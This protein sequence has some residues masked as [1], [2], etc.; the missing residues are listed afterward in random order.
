M[1][2]KSCVVSIVQSRLD[3]TRLRASSLNSMANDGAAIVEGAI[4]LLT[5]A[6]R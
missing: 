6:D 3:P 1:Q 5:L 2:L 4:E